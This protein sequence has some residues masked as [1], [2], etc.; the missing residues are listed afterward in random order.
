M[1]RAERNA[2]S[3]SKS[4]DSEEQVNLDGTEDSMEEE[5]VEYEEVEEEVEEEDEEEEIEEEEE[6]E[7]VDDEHETKNANSNDNNMKID[8]PD[9]RDEDEIKKHNELLALPPHGSEIYLGGIPLDAT[10]EDIKTFCEE[11]G[12][13]HEIRVMKEKDASENRGFAFVTFKTKDIAADAIENLNGKE[14]K[15]KRVK[16]STSQ[17]KYK[18]FIGNIPTNWELEKLEKTVRQAGPGVVKV[19]LM[20]DQNS[21]RNRGFAFVEYYN[22]ACAEYSRKKMCTPKFKLD[23]KA[24]TVSWADTKNSESTTN[25]QIKAVYVKNLP[26]DVTQDKLRKLFEHHGEIS[27]VVLPPAKPGKE[28]RFGFVHFEQRSS[29]LKA[30]KNTEKYE[31]DGD[32]LDCSIAKPPSN[33]NKTES[34]SNSQKS[35]LLPNYTPRGY[36][37]MGALGGGFGLAPNFIPPMMYGR[38]PAPGGMAMVPMLLPDGRLGYVLQQPGAAVTPP[39]AHRNSGR[40]SNSSSGGG[41]RG[42]DNSYRSGGS[43]SGSGR[44]GSDGNS[45]GRRFHPY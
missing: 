17:A 27:K 11:A 1:P 13:I 9:D 10:E 8:E 42:S 20:K 38:G 14:L 25:S 43:S 21:N 24:P 22:H 30:L 37:G 23:N 33:D 29:A 19:N 12:E 28:K 34:G 26:N 3:A 40:S 39:P 5:E 2:R 31:L 7:E 45:R 18:L 36:T 41:H 44:K 16:C 4:P 6:E 15:G 32:I 35:G